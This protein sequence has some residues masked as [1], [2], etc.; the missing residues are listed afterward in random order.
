MRFTS[1]RGQSLVEFT[2]VL[3]LLIITALGVVEVSYVLLDQH[4]VTKL[5]REGSNLISR[6]TTLGDAATAMRTMSTRPVDLDNGSRIIFSVVR[7]VPTIGAANY[8]QPILAQRYAYGPLAKSST[9]QTAG[10]ASFGSGP[11][12]AAANQ[13]SNTNLRVTNLP[14]TLSL[15]ATLYITELYTSHPS[16]TPLAGFGI[17][18]PDTLYSI[19]YF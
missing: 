2:L 10:P 15:G 18:V 19:A 17:E 1:N 16:I 8:N 14:V 6:S 3:P 4:I 7:N 13:D 5:T 11:E 12:Y 9:I